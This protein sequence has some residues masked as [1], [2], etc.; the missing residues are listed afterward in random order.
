MHRNTAVLIIFLGIFAAIVVGVNLGHSSSKPPL[1][2]AQPTPTLLP[3]P[4][5]IPHLTY[6]NDDCGISLEYP[7]NYTKVTLET[8]A[9][10]FL[11]PLS[12]IDATTIQCQANLPKIIPKGATSSTL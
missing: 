1:A 5:P 8:G 7:P 10:T 4:S 11:N 6:T 12:P 9:T 2:S 3:T